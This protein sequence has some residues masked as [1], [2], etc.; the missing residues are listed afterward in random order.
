MIQPPRAAATPASPSASRR[1]R[2]TFLPFSPPSIGEEEIA[3]VVDTLRSHWITT[4]PKTKRF[5]REFACALGLDKDRVLMLNSCTAGLH[6]ALVALG[7]GP[8]DE[9]IVPSLTFAASANVVEHVGATPVLVDIDPYTLCLNP[10]AAERA[11]T[12]RTRALMVVHHSGHPADLAPLDR[13]TAA[14]D[15]AIVEDAAHALPS[16]YRGV[17]I[18]SRPTLSAFSF[19]AT[20][21]MTTAEGGALTG[22]PELIERARELSLH[23]MTKGAWTRYAKGGSWL[24]DITYPGFKYNMTDLQ[25]ALG[26]HQLRKLPRFHARRARIASLYTQAFADHPALE[27]PYE[28]SDVTSSWHL[29]VLR[30]RPE[31]LSIGRDAFIEE[32]GARNIGTSVHFRPLHLMSYY[33]ETYGYTPDDFPVAQDAYSR[34]ISLPLY[35]GLS[36]DDVQDVI[37]A[38]LEVATQH[39]RA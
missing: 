19:Y 27:T 11:L 14:H 7:V 36:D 2:A 3:E 29:Y 20:K 10:D 25:A 38:V 26:L 24:Y 16:T 30:L 17:R 8:G 9:V 23:G 28:A 31:G 21:N 6:L 15:L 33:A 4:G 34:M 37:H 35:P 18:G 5:E 32:L 13:L 12:S 1:T 39:L 22:P